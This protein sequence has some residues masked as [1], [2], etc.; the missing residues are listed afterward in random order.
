MSASETRQF[1][2]PV[3]LSLFPAINYG[4]T[5]TQAR[6]YIMMTLTPWPDHILWCD[7]YPGLTIY[8]GVTTTL[9]QPYTMVTPTLMPNHIP[10]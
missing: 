8:Y 10:W 5:L 6:P 9:A 4:D 1:T 3:T 7:H 2:I